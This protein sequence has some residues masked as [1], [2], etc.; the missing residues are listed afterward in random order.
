M[1]NTPRYA[2]YYAAAPGSALTAFGA[3]LLGYDAY[4]GEELPFP[5]GVPADWRE[6][7]QDPRK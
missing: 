5:D 4:S 1:A 2:I 7:T 3:S 6:L